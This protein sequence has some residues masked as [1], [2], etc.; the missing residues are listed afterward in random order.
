MY[1][2]NKITGLD[3]YREA[4]DPNRGGLGAFNAFFGNTADR[5]AQGRKLED[6]K[7]EANWVDR[8]FGHSTEELT[9]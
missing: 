6:G 1:D 5:F 9:E 3:K 2:I 8:L 7:I 4:A